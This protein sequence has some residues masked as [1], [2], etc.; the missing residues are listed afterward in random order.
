VLGELRDG[1]DYH[2]APASRF[3][4]SGLEVVVRGMNLRP[5]YAKFVRCFA[6]LLPASFDALARSRVHFEFDKHELTAT[7][8]ARLDLLARY[9]HADSSVQKVFVDGHTDGMGERPYNARLSKRRAERV[10]DYL[11]SAGLPQPLF[12]TRYH[13]ARYPLDTNETDA[14]RARNRRTTVRLV[15]DAAQLASR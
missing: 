12:V 6:G 11:V 8:K 1:Y 15:R 10:R 4:G 7:S 13:G 2:F 3:H 9:L 5:I 14:G